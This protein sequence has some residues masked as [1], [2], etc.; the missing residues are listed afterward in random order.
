MTPVLNTILMIVAALCLLGA[1]YFLF[2]G[3]R[4]RSEVPESSYGVERQ[5]VRHIVLASYF[6]SGFLFCLALIL[7]AILGIGNYPGPKGPED[8]TLT[9]PGVS[10]PVDN[11]AVN[12]T[13]T[14]KTDPTNRP[15]PTS[16]VPTLTPTTTPTAIPTDTPIVIIAIVTSP[17]GLWLRESP[18]GTQEVELIA[19]GAELIVLDGIEV[20]DDIEWQFV[21]TPSGLEGWVAADFIQVNQ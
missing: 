5:E 9:N 2:V 3:L 10:T 8:N 18:G 13:A 6:R 20:A 17:N 14:K 19:D 7:V 15:S 16:P 12:P 1:L 11:D 21:R 4:S